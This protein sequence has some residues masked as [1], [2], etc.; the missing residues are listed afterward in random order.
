MDVPDALAGLA[1]SAALAVSDIPFEG[2]ISEVRVARVDGQYVVNPTF[3]QLAKADMDIMVGATYENIM[4]V[5]GEMDEC[6]EAELLEAM[7]VAHEAIK[8][9]C[10][11]Q[12]ELAEEVGSTTKREYC[13]EVNDEDLRKALHEDTYPKCYALAEAGDLATG[14]TGAISGSS[15]TL[16]TVGIAIIGVVAG[17][18]VIKRVIG[19]IR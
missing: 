4:M 5:E 1:A 8:V 12:M 18:W 16:Q 2:P 7:K 19:L 6:S 9:Q 13:D 15:G 11:A 3:D 14:A 10:K 17:I